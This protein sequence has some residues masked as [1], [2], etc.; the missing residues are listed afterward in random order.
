MKNLILLDFDGVLADNLD[1]MLD[2]AGEVC[3]QLGYPCQPT[4]ADLEALETMDMVSYGR[5][6]GLPDI[7]L[8]RFAN[9]LRSMFTG[10]PSPSRIFP[11]L[12]EVLK[13]QPQ[14]DILAIITGN[15]RALVEAFLVQHTLHDEI[16]L[17]YSGD[18][19]GTRRHKILRAL[20]DAGVSSSDACL[21]SDAV[22]DIREARATDLYS[23]A[24][25]WGYQ[26]RERLATYRPD[27]IAET[28]AELVEALQAFRM[29]TRLQR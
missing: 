4:Q 20:H 18:L 7:A 21:V 17:I 12:Q 1:E 5:Q 14:E 22:S 13:A 3:S 6:L 8:E 15:A 26:S 16:R 23:I 10:N 29:Q 2:F 9:R 28:P 11:G 27:A 25:T 19:P 24:V